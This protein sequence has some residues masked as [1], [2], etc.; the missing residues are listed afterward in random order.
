MFFILSKVFLFLFSPFTWLA[1][2]LLLFIYVKNNVWKKRFLWSTVFIFFFF[3]NG[4]I[5]N[6]L[7]S[8]WEIDGIKT[9]NMQ[10]FENGI[11]LSGMF[12]YNKD[13]DRLS[14][15]RGSDRIWQTIQLYKKKK[16]KRIIITG[17][18][19]YV[20]KKGLH[21]AKQLKEVL[22]SMGIPG[23][24]ILIE[25]KSRN[26]HENAKETKAL[27][28]KHG[29]STKNNLLITSSMHMRRAKACFEEEGILCTPFTTDHYIVHEESISMTEFIPSTGAFKMW[30]RLFK[31]WI[32]Y[33]V[34]AIMGYL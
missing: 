10:Q 13:L 17:D 33:S 32:G 19:G 34:Y 28:D 4:F 15:R 9:E 24:D 23:E 6:R 7:I 3:S 5:V 8:L 20:F 27:M 1:I 18:S 22:I 16:I 30:D 21:E 2:S 26:T 14:A 12:E 31:E 11:V 25:S 29:L